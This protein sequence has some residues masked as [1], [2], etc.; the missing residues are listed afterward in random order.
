MITSGLDNIFFK[1]LKVGKIIS[2]TKAQGYQN[3]IVD[4]YYRA[5]E[6]GYFQMIRNLK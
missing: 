5:N 3:A 1:G 6:P 4:Q 2:V